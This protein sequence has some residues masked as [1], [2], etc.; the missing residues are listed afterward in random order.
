M[1]NIFILVLYVFFN[2]TFGIAQ[3][4]IRI[5]AISG[6]Y[7][8]IYKP[9]GD[10][11]NG[12]NSNEL[13][14]GKYY[15]TWI[16]NDHCFIKD[17]RDFWHLFG[18]THPKTSISAIHEG[19]VMSFHAI[20]PQGAFKQTL[21]KRNWKDIPK[22]LTPDKRPG[23]LP[24]LYAPTCLKKSGTYHLIWGPTA[25]L[26]YATSKDLYNW[27]YQG[28]LKNTP[29]NRD[30][31]VL[32]FDGKY[33]LITCGLYCINI[34]T[35]DDFINWTPHDP[36]ISRS[37]SVDFESPKLI[38][39]NG[40]FYLFA[41]AWDNSKWD[42][43][44]ISGAYQHITYVYQSD[45]IFKFSQSP[46]TQ[47]NAHAPEIM[48]DEDGDWYISSAEWPNRGVSVAKLIWKSGI[49]ID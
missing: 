47:I 7:V 37:D 43:K 15:K 19:E 8:H 18:I 40:T 39:Y 9:K 28:M 38:R 33:Y 11:Y 13:K 26:R 1:K 5:P 34:A 49:P 42:R 6:E 4:E 46:I 17:D 41:C 16:P 27:N 10:I 25:P 36:I 45:N 31:D 35:S 22:V 24:D 14:Q 21:K 48:Q 30:P 12:P 44:S 23:D 32:F 20:A 29:E 2:I 3:K